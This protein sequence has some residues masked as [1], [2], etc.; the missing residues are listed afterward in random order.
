MAGRTERDR[1]E[2]FVAGARRDPLA[3]DHGL[4][5]AVRVLDLDWLRTEAGELYRRDNGRP[6]IDPEVAVRPMLAACLHGIVQDRRRMRGEGRPATG[7][8]GGE[9][10]VSS[11][12]TGM[13]PFSRTA[14]PNA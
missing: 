3:E 2:V 1:L 13:T 4:V 11:M 10:W 8:R 9:R 5:R 6:G 14:R 12:R 7:A